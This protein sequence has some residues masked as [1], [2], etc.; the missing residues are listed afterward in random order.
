MADAQ[1]IIMGDGDSAFATLA[2]VADGLPRSLPFHAAKVRFGGE[3]F[4]NG[5]PLI[6]TG[7]GASDNW[8]VNGRNRHLSVGYI[9]DVVGSAKV[10]PPPEGPLGALLAAL[11]KPSKVNRF[12]LTNFLP[13][14]KPVNNA[15]DTVRADARAM[16][17][18][19]V[20]S[21]GMPVPCP[22]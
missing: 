17:R 2:A 22:L 11:G 3:A 1:Q 14:Q 9:Q 8:W 16:L 5:T 13:A 6:T 7:V 12:P 20:E 18:E 4:G 19:L 15:L 21:A 10:L